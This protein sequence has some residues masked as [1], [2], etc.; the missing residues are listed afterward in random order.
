MV[1]C[2]CFLLDIGCLNLHFKKISVSG[3][4]S[5]EGREGWWDDDLEG[6]TVKHGGQLRLM[7]GTADTPPKHP[8]VWGEKNGYDSVSDSSVGMK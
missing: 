2:C 1:F 7:H 5:L 6:C 4:E 8:G 3:T